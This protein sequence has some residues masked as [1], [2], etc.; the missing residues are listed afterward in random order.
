MAAPRLGEPPVGNAKARAGVAGGD[1]RLLDELHAEFGRAGRSWRE[2]AT[3]LDRILVQVGAGRTTARTL[4]TAGEWLISQQPDLL[5][6]RA[7]LIRSD[8]VG[9]NIGMLTDA[10]TQSARL[11]VLTA[12]LQQ[13][14]PRLAAEL[15]RAGVD[16]SND[17]PSRGS[18][19]DCGLVE[20]PDR[21][22]A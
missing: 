12:Q 14:D 9:L 15:Q 5:R 16:L 22:A 6:R 13:A 8:Q 7:D 18:A 4:D 11:A 10:V 17:P 2:A 20:I 1:V 3:R 21:S 19:R